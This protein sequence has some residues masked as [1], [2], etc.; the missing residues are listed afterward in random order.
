MITEDVPAGTTMAARPPHIT[1]RIEMKKLFIMAS[2]ALLLASCGSDEYE[3][4]AKPQANGAETAGEV[5]FTVA[6]AP[7]IDFK[8]ETADSVQLFVDGRTLQQ[9]QDGDTECQ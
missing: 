2:A 7:A 4:W 1:R 3:E 5:R 6:E 8:T 9:Q